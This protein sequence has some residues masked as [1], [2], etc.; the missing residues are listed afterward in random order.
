[1]KLCLIAA[2]LV[3]LAAAEQKT[4]RW[5]ISANHLD[6]NVAFYNEHKNAMSGFYG[7]CGGAHVA[8][9]GA[10]TYNMPELQNQTATYKGLG[11]TYHIMGSL[12]ETGVLNGGVLGGVADIVA[13]VKASGS[14]GIIFDYEPKD[15]PTDE[16]A[17]KYANFL[18]AVK[19]AA[20]TSFD[21]G[22]DVSGWGI[23]D[24][25]PIYGAS[26]L[27][28]Y[29]SMATTYYAKSALSPVG[30]AFMNNM[31]HYF[32]ADQSFYGIGTWDANEATC[33]WHYGWNASALTTFLDTSNAT[34]I[35][36]WRCD[37]DNYSTPSPDIYLPLEQWFHQ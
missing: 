14:D 5:Y 25:F 1:M 34:H 2:L 36:L 22:M 20:G 17:Q 15:Q 33:K 13:A 24:K 4:L 6:A 35:D 11:L 10:V 32:G 12:N 29:T 3:S 28:I 23:L 26:H 31:T 21:V 16:H 37:M 8:A 9:N 7:C 19:K 18:T 27:D 30:T